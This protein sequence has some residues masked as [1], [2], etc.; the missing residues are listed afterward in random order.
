MLEPEKRQQAIADM[1]AL[2]KTFAKLDLPEGMIGQFTS[3]PRNPGE[4]VFALTTQ[5]LSA[6]LTTNGDALPVW[7]N[8]DCGS[9]S[10][11]KTETA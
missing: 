8:P 3:P 11:Q 1:M 5:T 9:R 2:R 6:D 10:I 4:C 7:G